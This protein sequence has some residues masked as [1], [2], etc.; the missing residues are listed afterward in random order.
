M[1]VTPNGADFQSDDEASHHAAAPCPYG[2]PVQGFDRHMAR[3]ADE[4]LHDL[5]AL[6]RLTNEAGARILDGVARDLAATCG[7][8]SAEDL[9]RWPHFPGWREMA[10][11]EAGQGL[12][13]L[14]WLARVVPARDPRQ[15]Q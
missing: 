11:S 12:D 7:V 5:L 4:V 9:C 13:E 1:N 2:K 6:R 15:A 8:R 10:L 14:R 3:I